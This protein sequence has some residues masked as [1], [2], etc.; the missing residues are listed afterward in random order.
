MS[1]IKPYTKKDLEPT[2]IKSTYFL[3]GKLF[4]ENLWIQTSDEVTAKAAEK[5]LGRLV[6]KRENNR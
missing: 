5:F 6:I 1:Q 4:G 3:I 2:Q